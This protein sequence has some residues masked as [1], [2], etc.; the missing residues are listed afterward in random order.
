MSLSG[1]LLHPLIY[2]EILSALGVSLADLANLAS[3][4]PATVAAAQAAVFATLIQEP[5]GAFDATVPIPGFRPG[6][7]GASGHASVYVSATIGVPLLLLAGFE[8]DASH[9]AQEDIDYGQ[10]TVTARDVVDRETLKA[11]VTEA[12]EYFV[13]LQ[14]TGG[15]AASSQA[16]IALRDP[17]GPW[18]HGSV[19][20]YVLE[21]NSNVILFHGAFPDRFELQPLTPTVRDVVTG[22]FVLTQVLEA[23]ASSP[24]G[25]FVQYYW[26]M[27]PPTTRTT[28]TYPRLA[29]P[30]SSP[31]NSRRRTGSS[32]GLRPPGSPSRA[33]LGTRWHISSRSFRETRT[34]S[35]WRGRAGFAPA[36]VGPSGLC[37]SGILADA[38][39]GVNGKTAADCRIL[40]RPCIASPI[41]GSVPNRR[42]DQ[43]QLAVAQFRELPAPSGGKMSVVLHAEAYEQRCPPV[44]H[45]HDLANRVEGAVEHRDKTEFFL[46]IAADGFHYPVIEVF[47]EIRQIDEAVEVTGFVFHHDFSLRCPA[48]LDELEEQPRE[49]LE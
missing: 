2:F 44:G 8:L 42:L 27:I 14:E 19:Y 20:L 4:D 11:F 10:P 34:S 36:S 28:P 45:V 13:E 48:P 1:G 35:Q 46:Q 37:Y 18:R 31:A 32:P 6:I 43:G 24:E 47:G 16:R 15:A 7:P 17:N 40:R 22:E 21:R 26:G 9:L 39:K 29:T 3:P 41:F 38:V 49:G 33:R 5:D 25:G 30:A 23:A 12:G